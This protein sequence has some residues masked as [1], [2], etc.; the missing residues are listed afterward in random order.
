MSP[1]LLALAFRSASCAASWSSEV[2]LFA[3]AAR[4]QPRSVRAHQLYGEALAE[5]DRLQEAEREL[6]LALEMLGEAPEVPAR[7][8]VELG[9]VL[10]RQGRLREA[11]AGYAGLLARNPQE[12]E[13]LWRLG[14][15]RWVSGARE[16][17]ERLWLRAAAAAP[18]DARILSDLGFAAASRGDLRT[19][20]E[21]WRRA[22]RLDPR[23]SGPWLQLGGMMK[24]A[25]GEP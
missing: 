9:V 11:E 15:V 16:E 7:A 19:A 3:H 18:E 12:P 23:L 22:I 25:G 24:P 5:Q 4:A 21:R 17:A 20:E 6:R 8:V 14:V 10:E 1:A 2:A 13:A